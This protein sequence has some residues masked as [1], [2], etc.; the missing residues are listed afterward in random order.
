M[1]LQGSCHGSAVPGTLVPR[2]SVAASGGGGTRASAVQAL[3]PEPG[4]DG[5]GA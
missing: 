5:D 4:Y 3:V 1:N 2:T